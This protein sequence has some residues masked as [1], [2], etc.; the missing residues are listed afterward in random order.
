MNIITIICKKKT[1]S[2][3]ERLFEKYCEKNFDS[4]SKCVII[5]I[6]IVEFYLYI[7]G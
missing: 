2:K 4:D 1:R 3:P 5:R 6:N 7:G